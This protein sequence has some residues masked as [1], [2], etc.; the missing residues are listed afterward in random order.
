M[1]GAIIGE[2]GYKTVLC[3]QKEN[4]EEE[5]VSIMDLHDLR[6]KGNSM[7]VVLILDL[8]V[9]AQQEM[10]NAFLLSL[11][12]KHHI[13]PV[14]TQIYSMFNAPF[15]PS[16][17]SVQRESNDYLYTRMEL[18]NEGDLESYVQRGFD[19]TLMIPSFFFQM[20]VSL[21]IAHHCVSLWIFHEF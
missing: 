18:A 7:I 16:Y 6:R 12:V 13:V 20:I 19:E 2:G 1:Q 17:I 8:L 21:Y 14:Y 4:G 3:C 11:L 15:T 10:Q 9:V 5:A